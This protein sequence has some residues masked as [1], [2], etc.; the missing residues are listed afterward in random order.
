[1]PRIALYVGLYGFDLTGFDVTG[2]GYD[3]PA[4]TAIPW[5]NSAT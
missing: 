2:V 3:R 5:P 1:M 4:E